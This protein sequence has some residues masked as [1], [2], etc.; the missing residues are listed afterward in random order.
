LLYFVQLGVYAPYRDKKVGVFV[1]FH[2][3]ASAIVNSIR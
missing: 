3:A 1:R 2:C